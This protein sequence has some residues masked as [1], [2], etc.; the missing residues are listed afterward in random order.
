M[1]TLLLLGVYLFKISKIIF[2]PSTY[3]WRE[4]DC[5]PPPLPRN[6]FFSNFF[7]DEFFISTAVSVAVR[8]SFR[9]I[10]TQVWWESVAMVT[11]YDAF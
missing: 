11:I 8:I 10:S 6:V 7:Q 1:T 9:H 3:K 4:A 5:P 2:N